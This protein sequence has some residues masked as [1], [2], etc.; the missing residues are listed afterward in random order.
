MLLDIVSNIFLIYFN[1]FWMKWSCTLI[2]LV[3]KWSVGFFGNPI[4]LW[5]SH[6]MG[7][8]LFLHKSP[9]CQKFPKSNN[10]ICAMVSS[11]V[12]HLCCNLDSS[13]IGCFLHF[14]KITPMLTKKHISQDGSLVISITC[15]IE[16]TKSF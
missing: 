15:A 4:R 13:M 5:L 7:C 2:C 1:L 10:L 16:I 8:C 12:L 11:H 6:I 9:I 14:H 3:H